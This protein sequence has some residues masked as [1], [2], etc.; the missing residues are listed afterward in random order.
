MCSKGPLSGVAR[1]GSMLRA[2]PNAPARALSLS[3][4]KIR[5]SQ[6]SRKVCEVHLDVVGVHDAI[7]ID[8]DLQETAACVEPRFGVRGSRTAIESIAP[9]KI[10]RSGEAIGARQVKHEFIVGSV[11]TGDLIAISRLRVRGAGEAEVVRSGAGC[12]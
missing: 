4:Y 3:Q 11:Q 8:V 10:D 5:I 1:L 12:H 2:A 9:D 6:R 7:A